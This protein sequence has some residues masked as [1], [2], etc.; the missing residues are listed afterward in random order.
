MSVES[1]FTQSRVG[2]YQPAFQMSKS[3]F[4]GIRMVPVRGLVS[5]FEVTAGPLIWGEEIKRNLLLG[6]PLL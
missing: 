3:E 1:L 2:L 6:N 4:S 5:A